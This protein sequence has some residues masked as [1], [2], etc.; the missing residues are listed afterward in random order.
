MKGCTVALLILICSTLSCFSQELQANRALF[1]EGLGNGLTYS[2][3]YD[4][5]F[6]PGP[7]GL[8]GRGGIGFISVQGVNITSVPFVL[9]YLLGYSGHYVE[10]GIGATILAIGTGEEGAISR[11][12]FDRAT[13]IGAT[14]SLGY[15]YQPL[16]GGLMFRAGLAPI[17]DRTG[18]LPFWPQVSL[19]YAF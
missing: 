1:I 9:N 7:N 17:F 14:L 2:L 11:S 10:F 5:R 15:R 16:D 6:G 4:T 19:G 8:G 12:E 13:G 18:S 3:N